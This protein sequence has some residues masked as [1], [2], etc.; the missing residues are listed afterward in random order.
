[1]NRYVA[2]LT[3]GNNPNTLIENFSPIDQGKI[4]AST[5]SALASLGGLKNS[6]KFLKAADEILSAQSAKDESL[7]LALSKSGERIASTLQMKKYK[8]ESEVDF[9]NLAISINK[10]YAIS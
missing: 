8:N 2:T 4:F 10:K 3:L 6:E 7:V 1:M 9:M 5:A